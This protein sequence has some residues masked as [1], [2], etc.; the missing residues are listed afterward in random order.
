MTFSLRH[1]RPTPRPSGATGQRS[2]RGESLIEVLGTVVLMGLGFVALL[3]GIFTVV[4]ISDIN[5]ER[6]RASIAVQ[7]YAESLIQPALEIPAVTTPTQIPQVDFTTYIPCATT[8]AYGS[9]PS[10]AIPVN[11]SNQPL[12]TATVTKV[13]YLTGYSSGTPTWSANVNDCYSTF[14]Y[15]HQLQTTD[16]AGN[17]V[18]YPRDKGL[19]RITVKLDS[20][21]RTHDDRVADTLTFVKRDQRCPGTFDNADLGPC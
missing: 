20:G 3:N 14:E 18:Y 17:T 10:G 19:Q 16:P 5:Q 8:G 2:E 15:G 13:E 4:K 21:A 11:S 1:A 12:F 9:P 6:T 7:A